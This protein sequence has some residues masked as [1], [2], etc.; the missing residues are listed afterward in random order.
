MYDVDSSPPVVEETA[1]PSQYSS[2]VLR[3]WTSSGGQTRVRLLDVQSGA[4]YPA[5][6]LV[7]LPDLLRRLIKQARHE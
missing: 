7:E 1:T 6:D 3:C 4:S 2:F 5:A